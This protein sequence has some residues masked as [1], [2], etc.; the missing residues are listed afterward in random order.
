M[1]ELL[2][3]VTLLLKVGPIR[4]KVHCNVTLLDL[5]PIDADPMEFGKLLGFLAGRLEIIIFVIEVFKLYS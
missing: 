5:Q 4:H 1:P 2:V 3:I